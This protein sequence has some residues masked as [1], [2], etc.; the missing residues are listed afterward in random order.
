MP[1]A[2]PAI[3]GPTLL[4]QQIHLLSFLDDCVRRAMK[5]PYRYIEDLQTLRGS[6]VVDGNE[7]LSP[8]MSTVLE[9][10]DAKVMG[11]HIATDA[12]G[13]VLAYL[14]RVMLGL[15]GKQSDGETLEGIAKRIEAT[16]VKAKDAGQ[17]R[18]GL[19]ELLE[20]IKGDLRFPGSGRRV[21]G[22]VM[23]LADERWVVVSIQLL[24]L[25]TVCGGKRHS[26]L[27]Q[28]LCLLCNGQ[29]NNVSMTCRQSAPRVRQQISDMVG[30]CSTYSRAA[31]T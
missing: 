7:N 14:R 15:A 3:S 16:L 29:I 27:K 6:N 11:Q 28:S 9:Q 2:S 17:A 13:V 21:T 23:E 30:S 25:P 20:G 10:F 31:A 24:R 12:A 4:V 22:D 26:R 8:V 19:S 18:V 5:T 1:R